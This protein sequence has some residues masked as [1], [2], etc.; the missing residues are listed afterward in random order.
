VN[1]SGYIQ[2]KHGKK[3]VFEHRLIMEKRLNR[4]LNE[5][6]V[7]HHKNGIK[8]DNRVE[9]LVVITRADH[10]KEHYFNDIKKQTQWDNVQHLGVKSPHI[11]RGGYGEPQKPRPEPTQEG[12]TWNHHKKRVGFI[13]RKCKIC[14]KLFWGRKDYK[15]W[16]GFCVRCSAKNMRNYA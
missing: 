2:I 1:E 10:A 4:K 14:F 16:A 12:M 7:V 13:V 11:G 6:E 5:C 8:N 15:K 3:F 9:N